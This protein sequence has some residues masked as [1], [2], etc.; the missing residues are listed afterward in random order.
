MEP[1]DC[2]GDETVD[3]SRSDREVELEEEVRSL[4]RVL[5]GIGMAALSAAGKDAV[6]RQ[7]GGPAGL[8]EPG[9]RLD[10]VT[11]RAYR[12]GGDR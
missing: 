1:S 9:V 7:Q 11:E 5:A 6:E 4:R 2:R 3:D 10:H 8:V 12:L